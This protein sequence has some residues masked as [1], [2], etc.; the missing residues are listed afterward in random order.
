MVPGNGQGNLGSWHGQVLS[1]FL[2]A[3]L[4]GGIPLL[5]SS[6][7]TAILLPLSRYIEDL[8]PVHL[9]LL[10][11]VTFLTS[12]LFITLLF[13]VTYKTLSEVGL[14]WQDVLPGSTVTAILFVIGNFV[15]GNFVIAVYVSISDI[16]SAHGAAGSIVVF[17]FWIY[18][19]AQIFLFG[20]ELIKVSKRVKL[21]LATSRT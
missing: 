7:V 14:S 12:F 2:F 6:V 19:S 3:H 8:L 11:L 10:R 20:A 1:T 9:E 18:Y 21:R 17:L 15:I 13:A 5:A 4:A 16:S